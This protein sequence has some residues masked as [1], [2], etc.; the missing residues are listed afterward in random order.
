MSRG[1]KARAGL[2][3]GYTALFLCFAIVLMMRGLTP[4]DLP[5]GCTT[6]LSS[7]VLVIRGLKSPEAMP[8]GCLAILSLFLSLND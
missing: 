8:Y 3:H 7:L 4:A 6:V 5:H 2:P 1:T